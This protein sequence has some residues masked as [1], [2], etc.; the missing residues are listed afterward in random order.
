MMSY[1]SKIARS[2][3]DPKIVATGP[4]SLGPADRLARGLGWFSLALGALEV[5]APERI[6]RALGMQGRE[7]LVRSYGVR[8][9]ASGMMTL[10]PDKQTGLWTRVAGDGVDIATLMTAFRD[11]NDRKDNVG[12]ALAMVAGVMLLDI[13]A[14]Q[15]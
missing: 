4:S 14:A 1:L 7:T 3:G 11:D 2:E 6:T 5:V 13:A 12:A 9:I 15:A 8:E 10:S